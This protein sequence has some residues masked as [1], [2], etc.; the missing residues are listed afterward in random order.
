[1][2]PYLS[3]NFLRF[4]IASFSSFFRCINLASSLFSVSAKPMPFRPCSSKA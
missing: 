2:S 4:S 3:N 1:M